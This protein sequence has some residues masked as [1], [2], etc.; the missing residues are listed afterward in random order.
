MCRDSLILEERW[1]A[2]NDHHHFSFYYMTCVM[3]SLSRERESGERLMIMVT[4]V[5]RSPI[6]CSIKCNVW[7]MI[8]NRTHTYSHSIV[9]SMCGWVWMCMQAHN[10]NL[11]SILFH[12][13]FMMRSSFVIWRKK[14][15]QHSKAHMY[16][17]RDFL[18]LIVLV[19][20]IMGCHIKIT[21]QS[22]FSLYHIQHYL[23]CIISNGRMI[24]DVNDDYIKIF[25]HHVVLQH[26][27]CNNYIPSFCYS[28]KLVSSVIPIIDS[29]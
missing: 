1:D 14:D 6:E 13:I 22:S 2:D 29:F 3:R 11:F 17:P 23:I 21:L 16:F 8:G 20:I 5:R 15:N 19:L 26:L 4:S 10:K 27:S 18:T 28:I 24:V 7:S 25:F 9:I 12:D